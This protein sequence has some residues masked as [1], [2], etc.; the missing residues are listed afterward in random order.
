MEQSGLNNA[1]LH[2]LKMMSFVKNEK[3]LDDIKDV[4]SDFF[5]QK[6]ED[7]MDKL[8]DEGKWDDQKNEAV[9]NQH[10]R[11]TYKR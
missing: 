8:W 10:L 9:L 3:T 7:G 2:L 5:A 11:T 1:Q 6:A 4:L